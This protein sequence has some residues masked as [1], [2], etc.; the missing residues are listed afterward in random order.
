MPALE[1]VNVE[2]IRK[3]FRKARDYVRAYSEGKKTG[4]RWKTQSRS[5][6]RIGE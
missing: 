6:S 2:L 4:R 3:F 1:T 5:T